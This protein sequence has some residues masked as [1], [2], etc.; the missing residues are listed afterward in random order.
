MEEP[1]TRSSAAQSPNPR[2]R[3]LISRRRSVED[4]G[5]HRGDGGGPCDGRPARIRTRYASRAHKTTCA[6]DKVRSAHKQQRTHAPHAFKPRHDG[7]QRDD[8]GTRKTHKQQTCENHRHRVKRTRCLQFAHA[9]GFRARDTHKAN[10]C[11]EAAARRQYLRA[12]HDFRPDTGSRSSQQRYEHK[13]NPDHT[14]R[15]SNLGVEK[16]P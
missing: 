8:G 9:E 13:C 14:R 7:P 11:H 6:G 10:E 4:H 16:P 15:E 12:Q 3:L 1:R 5:S 2:T